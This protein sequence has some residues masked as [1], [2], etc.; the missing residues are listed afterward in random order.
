MKFLNRPT[1]IALGVS[2]I[3]GL[4]FSGCNTTRGVGQDI[5]EAGEEIQDATN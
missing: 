4:L 3:A 5:E 1:L 2:L